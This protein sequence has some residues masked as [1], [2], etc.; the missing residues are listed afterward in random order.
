M[1]IYSTIFMFIIFHLLEKSKRRGHHCLYVAYHHRTWQGATILYR[2]SLRFE[3][4]ALDGEGGRFINIILL[5]TFSALT[6]LYLLIIIRLI[7]HAT[8]NR[9]LPTIAYNVSFSHRLQIMPIIIMNLCWCDGNC[10]LFTLCVHLSTRHAK[11]G[12]SAS[13][14]L[15]PSKQQQQ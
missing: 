2:R 10:I 11:G 7:S 9:D 4:C 6:V 12:E 14:P 5:Q 8:R 1:S 3:F 13:T 15:Y